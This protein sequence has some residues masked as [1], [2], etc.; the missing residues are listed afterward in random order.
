MREG[1]EELDAVTDVHGL[2]KR[3]AS[4]AGDT[5]LILVDRVHRC[6]GLWERNFAFADATHG[7]GV[8]FV[9]MGRSEPAPLK[10]ILIIGALR[11]KSS[12]R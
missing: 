3:L 11:K 9:A 7:V 5:K 10:Q 8:G 2:V 6:D 12:G 1:I 4:L